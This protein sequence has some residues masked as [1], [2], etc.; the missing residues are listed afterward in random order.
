MWPRSRHLI[1]SLIALGTTPAA[2]VAGDLR[3]G[4]EFC[5]WTSRDGRRWVHRDGV[6]ATLNERVEVGV[7]AV[8]FSARVLSAELER[9]IV[10]DPQGTKARDY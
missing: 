6:D 8:N 3:Q 5:A 10:N 4:H 7:V 9:F 2:L 1:A